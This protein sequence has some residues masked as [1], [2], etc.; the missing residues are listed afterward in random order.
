[1]YTL[2]FYYNEARGQDLQ[3]QALDDLGG[4]V[5]EGI[6]P[7]EGGFLTSTVNDVFDWVLEALSW[8]SPFAILKGLLLVM[9]PDI[10]YEPLNL[11]ILRPV[12]WIGSW[13]TTEWI[14]NKIRGSSEG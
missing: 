9:V 10:L 8:F 13:I 5:Q 6:E 4:Q 7:Q 11:L 14:I 3:A 1:M 12:G 2:S